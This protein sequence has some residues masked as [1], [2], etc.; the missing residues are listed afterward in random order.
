MDTAT[1]E[2]QGWNNKATEEKEQIRLHSWSSCEGRTNVFALDGCPPLVGCCSY[3]DRGVGV[4]EGGAEEE[5]IR[6]YTNKEENLFCGRDTV[7]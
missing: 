7:Q 4:L 1:E 5:A 2:A 3:T 6:E